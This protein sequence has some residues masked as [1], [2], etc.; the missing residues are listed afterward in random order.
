MTVIWSNR[1]DIDCELL[2][3]MW[4]SIPNVR[5]VE[6]TPEL[7]DFEEEVDSAISEEEDTLILTGHGTTEGLL[8]P[9]YSLGAYII[10]ENNFGL[11]RAKNVFCCWCYASSFCYRFD[12]SSFCS[13]MF[14]SNE[15]EAVFNSCPGYTQTQ[16]DEVNIKFYKEVNRLLVDNIPVSGWMK[17]LLSSIDHYN[18]VDSFNRSGLTWLPTVVE[19]SDRIKRL[20]CF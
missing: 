15:A 16:I 20:S 8:F 7:Y 6:I 5:V 13:S 19:P 12:R 4:S 14:I 17:P 1:G 2:E 11:I 9:D 3:N 18:L 10:H